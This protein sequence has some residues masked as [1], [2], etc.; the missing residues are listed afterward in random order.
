MDERHDRSLG[1]RRENASR[2]GRAERDASSDET[3][4][5]GE[6]AADAQTVPLSADTAGDARDPD[7]L[8]L[9]DWREPPTGEVPR[10]LEELAGVRAD[11]LGG[12]RTGELP[13]VDADASAERESSRSRRMAAERH[14]REQLRRA[15]READAAPA[16]AGSSRRSHRHSR[17]QGGGGPRRS[18]L[19]STLTGLVLGA[20]VIGAV[21]LGRI[22]VLVVVGLALELAVSEAFGVIEHAGVR[23]ARFIGLIGVGALVGVG[24]RFG[25]GPLAGT[26]VGVFLLGAAWYLFGPLR[27]PPFDG[28][29]RTMLVVVW[30]GLFGA[31]AAVLLRPESFGG[32]GELALLA[33]LAC[34]VADDTVAFF[35]GSLIGR[36]SLVPAISPA[37]TVE[38][39]VGGTLAAVATGL[40]LGVLSALGTARGVWLG[41]VVAVVAPLGDLLESAMKRQHQVKDSGALLPGHG[42]VL[43][44]IDAMLLVLPASYYLMLVMHLR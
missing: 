4:P 28:L 12:P 18:K 19:Q 23:E 17:S 33:A 43:D 39:L 25:P 41:V 16:A 20:I 10:I 11:E 2:G 38:G 24:Y 5:I 32:R 29:A 6:D 22:A 7:D 14:A 21:L 15:Q 3:V 13:I 36:H 42:G 34:V 26:I 27:R 30:V 8:T 9:R 44:R 37:K 1:R 35:V 40:V 31:F